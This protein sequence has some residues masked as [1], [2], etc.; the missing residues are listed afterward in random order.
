MI[1]RGKTNEDMSKIN[2]NPVTNNVGTGADS[3]NQVTP[4]NA[5]IGYVVFYPGVR[6]TIFVEEIVV[7]D[8]ESPEMARERTM[9][10]VHKLVR[11]DRT[12]LFYSNTNLSTEEEVV[13][14]ILAFKIDGKLYVNIVY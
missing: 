13:K 9:E 11:T 4:C 2:S 5:I 7:K 8:N 6:G 1:K 12:D 3:Q 10:K 14:D